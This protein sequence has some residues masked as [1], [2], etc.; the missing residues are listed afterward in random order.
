MPRELRQYSLIDRLL[1][2]VDQALRTASAGAPLASR[3]N[4]S[5][6]MADVELNDEQQQHIAGLMRINHT[7]EVCAQALYSGQA[8]TARNPA[9]RDSMQQAA[10]EEIDHLAW[11]EQRLQELDAN[12]SIFNG[13]WYA[14]S[15]SLG[16]VAG[17]LGDEWSLGFLRETE[18]Q[19]EAHLDDH[20]DQLPETD[21]KSRAILEQMKT[22]EAKHA[23]MAEDAGGRELPR[24]V[25]DLMR[26]SA[27][28]MKAVAYR[29]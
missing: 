6:E 3:S 17:L 5:A 13:L 28:F 15:W 12:P 25:Q 19:V 9:V 27:N 23:A 20:L 16:A 2:G 21:Q 22:D 29:L 1:S 24:P 8:A 11:C 10:D 18:H 7:G 14:G 26:M 4:P